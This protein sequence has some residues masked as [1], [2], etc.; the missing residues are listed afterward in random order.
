MWFTLGFWSGLGIGSG[1]SGHPPRARLSGVQPGRFIY[2]SKVSGS[3]RNKI[4]WRT[5]KLTF[6]FTLGLGLRFV[7]PA[8]PNRSTRPARFA[9]DTRANRANRPATPPGNR[10]DQG[11]DRESTNDEGSE[12]HFGEHDDRGCRKGNR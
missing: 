12:K 10:N 7:R 8:R 2:T 5:A 3:S 11:V 9:R 4:G 1:D 6:R